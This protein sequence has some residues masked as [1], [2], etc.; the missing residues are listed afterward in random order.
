MVQCCWELL[1]GEVV[2]DVAS[3]YVAE[4][5]EDR[6][7]ERFAAYMSELFQPDSSTLPAFSEWAD[8]LLN[9]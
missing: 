1:S 2:E 4:I 5:I 9:C 6:W 3:R 7:A 8:A